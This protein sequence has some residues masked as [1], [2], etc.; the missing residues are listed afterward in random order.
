MFEL[1]KHQCKIAH[2]NIRTEKHGEE[3]ILAADV[4]VEADVTNDFLSYLDPTLKWSLYAKPE[5]G[6]GELIQDDS[7]MPRLRY[8]FLPELRW[9]DKMA[10]AVFI[11]HGK[12]KTDDVE[13]EASVD[14]L[15]LQC[16]EGGTVSISFRA[17]VLPTPAQSGF[18]AGMLGTEAKVSV[19]EAGDPGDGDGGE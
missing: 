14:K 17:A 12:K 15:C 11:I 16:K 8:A 6:Q 2:I 18:L 1:S 10:K 5:G 9:A 7:H 13:F 4:K 19:R 3:E